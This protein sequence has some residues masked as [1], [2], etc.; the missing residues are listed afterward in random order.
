MDNFSDRLAWARRRAGFERAQ[1]AAE[2]FDW[3][4]NTYKSHDNGIR[5]D[6]RGPSEEVA[7]RYARAFRID[8]V[9]LML[10]IGSPEAKDIAHLAGRIGAGAR[11]DSEAEQGEKTDIELPFPIGPDLM[12]FEV[13]GDSMWPKFEDGD[14]IVC[15]ANETTNADEFIGRVVAVQTSDG[16]RYVK[17][18]ER[19]RGPELYNLES[20]NPAVSPMRDQKLD[21]VARI[22]SIVPRGE[23]RQLDS[24]TRTHLAEV[25]RRVRRR[26]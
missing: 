17:R 11:I 25:T 6:A 5:A 19:G 15:A 13:V 22:K 9:W 7:K 10:G 18:V 26:P 24:A 16:L 1:H 21:W 20:V 12:A 4:V 3:N 2:A 14:V 8:W 23:W